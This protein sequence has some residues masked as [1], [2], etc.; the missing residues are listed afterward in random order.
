MSDIDGSHKNAD[1]S[2]FIRHLEKNIEK[3]AS[4]VKTI[5]H[6]RLL[7]SALKELNELI[8]HQDIKESVALQIPHLIITKRR[9]QDNPDFKEDNVML[10]SMLYGPPGVG[11]TLIGNKLAKIWYSLGYLNAE[12]KNN[13]QSGVEQVL[14]DMFTEDGG[15]SNIEKYLPFIF[16]GISLISIFGIYILSG[17]KYLYNN[18]GLYWFLFLLVVL[19]FIL[20]CLYIYYTTDETPTKNNNTVGVNTTVVKENSGDI[21][22]MPPDEKIIKVVTREDFVD[23]YVGWTDKKTSKLLKDN[24]GKVLFVD[25]AYTLI[26]GPDDSFGKEAL[27]RLNLFLSQHPNQIIVIFAGYKDLLDAGPLAVQPGLK[28]RFMWQFECKGYNAKE[29]FQIFKMQM[30]KKGWSLS[31]EKAIEEIFVKNEDAFPAFGGDVERTGFFSGLEH[32]SDYIQRSKE[33]KSTVIEPHHVEAGISRLR[34]NNM[35]ESNDSKNPIANMM[36]AFNGK[37]KKS[38]TTK[39]SDFSNQDSV[40]NDDALI[41]MVRQMQSK[42]YRYA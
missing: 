28:R 30:N 34:K 5:R 40:L 36:R 42:Q 18:V 21:L 13:E 16:I 33:M 29:L 17:A 15:A 8:G 26:N 19:F 2:E 14:R 6:P 25:E 10:N 31:D 35:T 9:A 41:N 12:P 4:Y 11:K 24:L 3:N 38:D 39:A 27:D 23:K 1:L 32:S 20:F 7:V 22:E 37:T